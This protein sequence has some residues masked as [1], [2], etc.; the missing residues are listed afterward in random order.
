MF[1]LKMAL[2]SWA[3]AFIAV[4][5]GPGWAPPSPTLTGNGRNAAVLEEQPSPGPGLA[6][7]SPKLTGNGRNAAV[8]EESRLHFLL[9]K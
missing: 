7:P 6:Q 3:G 2:S 1:P 5:T 8:L 4:L 9:M